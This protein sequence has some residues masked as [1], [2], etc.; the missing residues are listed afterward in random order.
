M[1]LKVFPYVFTRYAAMHHR[2]FDAIRLS[3]VARQLYLRQMLQ[4]AIAA[5]R[6]ALC[7]RLYDVI[8]QEEDD[9]ARRILIK[10]KRDV[11]NDKYLSNIRLTDETTA[12]LLQHHISLLNRLNSLTASWEDYFTRKQNVHRQQLQQWCSLETLR[13]GLLLSSS[14]LYEQLPAFTAQ[15]PAAFRHKELKNEHS[16]LR[17]LSRMAF[18]TSPFSTFTHT[19]ITLVTKT[20]DTYQLVTP[21]HIRTSV[22]LNNSL[23]VHL[24]SIMLKHPGLNELLQISLNPT[25]TL[26]EKRLSFLVNCF[27][28]ESFQLMDAG[29]ITAWLYEFLQGQSS[30]VPL[31]ELISQLHPLV[32][33]TNRS[34]VKAYLLKLIDAGFLEAGTGCSDIHPNWDTD[35]L[36]LLIPYREAGP[37]VLSL[38]G[39]LQ[40]LHEVRSVYVAAEPS[41]RYQL[42]QDAAAKLNETLLTL[43]KEAGIQDAPMQSEEQAQQ[44]VAKLKASGAFEARHFVHRVFSPAGIFYED[45]STAEVPDLPE[46]VVQPIVVAADRLVN[47][48]LPLDTMQL[49]RTRM[50]QFFLKHYQPA[51][52]V[53]ITTFYHHYY[54]KEKKRL[55]EQPGSSQDQVTYMIPADKLDIHCSDLHHVSVSIKDHPSPAAKHSYSLGMFVQLFTMQEQG[56]TVTCGVLNSLLPGMGKVAGRFLDLFDPAATQLFNEWNAKLHLSHMLMELSDGSSFNANTHPPLLSYEV[57]MPGGHNNF[58][59][60]KQVA[61]KDVVVKYDAAAG[62]L[63][64]EHLPGKRRIYAYDLCLES[65]Y[66][67]SDFYQLLAHFNPEPHVSI[68][69]FVNAIDKQHEAGFD[70]G[71]GPVIIKPRITCDERLVL[72]RMGWLVTVGDMPIQQPGE[73]DAAWFLR[74][75]YWRREH[76][77]PEHIYLFVRTHYKTMPEEKSTTLQRDDYKPQYIHFESPLMAGVLKKLLSRAG[78]QVYMEEML[79]HITHLQHAGDNRPV[80][81]HLLHWYKC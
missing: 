6:D 51:N 57:C 75:Q 28:I 2:E 58:P 39:L 63:Y 27:N 30:P 3:G 24:E 33:G 19:G 5:S 15:H 12:R 10:L 8:S 37:A 60:H 52:E 77:I 18:K 34:A 66:L 38:I 4:Q 42:L 23:F 59:P 78:K 55:K 48:L 16:L 54:L 69:S 25:T 70:Q 41:K 14:V 50:R 21:S 40:H 43:G 79:P 61:L 73:S 62:T 53:A 72:R 17:Y 13:N 68:K 80:T 81:E 1:D 32:E 49:E 22:R 76:G 31:H 46:S 26:H 7:E 71:N 35:L 11:F 65:F 74:L 67:R 45:T 9:Q 29:S 44:V 64:L 47:V 20:V 56:T 36:Q